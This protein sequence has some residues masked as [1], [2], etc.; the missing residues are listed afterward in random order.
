MSVNPD[1]AKVKR[2]RPTTKPQKRTKIIV[3]ISST[4][5]RHTKQ[6][7]STAHLIF[8]TSKTNI[9]FV[10]VKVNCTGSGAAKK[11]VLVA[12]DFL[13]VVYAVGIEN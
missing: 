11:D 3:S 7:G 8:S 10:Y 4:S 5:A 2:S 13:A 6:H 1:D 9:Q 12:L